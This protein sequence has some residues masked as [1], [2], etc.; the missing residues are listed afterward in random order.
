M[1]AGDRVDRGSR[2]EPAAVGSPWRA[3]AAM[4]AIALGAIGA[5]AAPRLGLP[6]VVGALGGG[7]AAAL[8]VLALP[9]LPT[10]RVAVIM[11]GIAGLGALRHAALPTTDSVLI[12]L[13]AGATLLALVLVDR[14]EAESV[15]QLGGGTALAPRAAEVVRAGALIGAI[16]VAT[17]VVV[18]PTVTDE[19]GRKMW[20]GVLPSGNDAIAAPGSLRSTPE[21]D[22]T[23]RPRLSDRVVFTVDAPRPDFWRGEV[24]DQWSGRAWTRS[25][26]GRDA[27]PRDDD[28][29]QLLLDRFDDGAHTGEA[30]RQTFRIEAGFSE[31]V[32]AAPS[33]VE[34]QTDRLVLGRADGTAIVVGG[35]GNDAV[36]TVTSRSSLPTEAHLR[37]ATGPVP[38]DVLQQYAARPIAT[39]RVRALAEKITAGQ[40][41]TYDK[42]RAIEAWL[43]SHTEYSLDA[44]LSPKDRDVVDHFLF[45]SRVGW[46]E[47]VSS[48]L[49]VLAR[50]VGIPARLATGFVPGE[51]D[52]LSGRFVVR[53]RDAHA[54]TEIYFPGVG[55]QGFDPT[56][57]VPLAGEADTSGSWFDDLRRNAPQL[58]LVL[59]G[60]C[61]LAVTAPDFVRRVR[62]R[63][64]Q[65]TSWAARSYARLERYGRRV[66][67][68]RRASETPREY[69]RR[70]GDA[71]GE[72]RLELVGDAIDRDGFSARGADPE[73]RAAAEAVLA[74]LQSARR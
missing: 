58:A 61:W 37:A 71:V 66:G 52:G 51:R 3:V 56:A 16:V 13:W 36:Y 1:M 29:S 55:W 62:T 27:L 68:P 22:M 2:R 64:A 8:A 48:S 34:V 43:S 11:L 24:Y 50:S 38:E 31:V 45:E 15:P 23:S 9:S 73:T 49:A 32:F 4:S 59:V 33:P 57:A 70:I 53:E 74:E 14:A 5:A 40:G 17:A 42:I 6:T 60:L 20:P 67:Q 18:V 47:Q 44:P 35:L 65:R 54:W 10:R 41:T 39:T 30:M 21:L 7:L 12:V 19:L 46:C 63:I 28:S 69:A 72:A 25:D 26:G